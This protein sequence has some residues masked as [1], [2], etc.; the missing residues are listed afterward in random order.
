LLAKVCPDDE[1]DSSSSSLLLLQEELLIASGAQAYHRHH[2][3]QNC[4]QDDPRITFFAT[5]LSCKDQG[6][7][8]TPSLDMGDTVYWLMV[9]SYVVGGS[10]QSIRCTTSNQARLATRL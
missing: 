10:Q 3:L 6:A 2:H 9:V 5:H 7:G 8:Q 4:C 1:D